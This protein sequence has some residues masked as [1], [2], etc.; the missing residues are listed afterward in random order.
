[1]WSSDYPH[2]ESTLGYTRS[3]VAQVFATCSDADA[4]RIVAT[5]AQELFD[6]TV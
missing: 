5:N 4:R 3:A 2:N 1:M 6:I